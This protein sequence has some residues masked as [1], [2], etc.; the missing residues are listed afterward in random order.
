M[1][2]F[3]ILLYVDV[4]VGL[5]NEPIANSLDGIASLLGY[6]RHQAIENYNMKRK[7][8]ILRHIIMTLFMFMGPQLIKM[9][10]YM[11]LSLNF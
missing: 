9:L 2:G 7:H 1:R 5:I 3:I 6:P 10:M 8:E 4:C 11:P